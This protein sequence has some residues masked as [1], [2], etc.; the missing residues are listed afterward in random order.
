MALFG[1]AVCGSIP[2]NVT[3]ASG[4]AVP[5]AKVNI[6]DLGKTVTYNTTT[7]DSGNYSQPHLIVGSY[8]VRVEASGFSAYLKQPV[9]VEVDSVAQ[10]NAQLSVGSVDETVSATAEAA[11][12]KTERSEVSDVMTTKAVAELPVLGRHMSRL[13]FLVPG[14]QASLG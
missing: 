3:D 10:V 9:T 1:Q 4:A 14:V 5:N 11:I 7:N 6:T 13:Y 12:L 8:S 2:G